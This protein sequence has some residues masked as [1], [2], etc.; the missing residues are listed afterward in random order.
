[1]LA[2]IDVIPVVFKEFGIGGEFERGAYAF[3]VEGK[4]GGRIKLILGA[5]SGNFDGH[6]FLYREQAGVEGSVVQSGEQQAVVRINPVGEVNSPRN[7]VTRYQ[8]PW[9]GKS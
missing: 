3:A 1:V 4:D 8:Q 2:D 7:Y 6:V 5:F 9:Y